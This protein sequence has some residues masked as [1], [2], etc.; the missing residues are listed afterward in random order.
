[1]TITPDTQTKNNG[2]TLIELLVVIAIIAIL[3]AMLLP[4]LAKAKAKALTA[5]CISNERQIGIAMRMFVDDN[6]DHFPSNPDFYAGVLQLY[7]GTVG[8]A[9]D[10]MAGHLA[11][12][13]G[14]PEM[15]NIKE[16]DNRYFICP[17]YEKKMILENVK[18]DRF[19][20][21]AYYNKNANNNPYPFKKSD[22]AANKIYPFSADKVTQQTPRMAML[23]GF[24][25]PSKVPA[26]MDFDKDWANQLAY[27]PGPVEA[28]ACGS[29]KLSHGNTRQ[30]LYFD[31]HVLTKK[32]D[33]PKDKDKY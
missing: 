14:L 3:A 20:A 16:R 21:F 11:P 33:A 30:H 4:A 23:S 26:L 22:I 27:N 1:M 2:F 10:S 6:D 5:N 9:K 17:A 7:G 19:R 29:V 31:G 15:D 13:M 12:Y 18:V 28:D 32:Q 8:A 25:G 24:G